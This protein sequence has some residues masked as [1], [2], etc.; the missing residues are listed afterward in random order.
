MEGKEH[1][2]ILLNKLQP[3]EIKTKT[4]RRTRLLNMIARNL[5]KKVTLLCA[6]AGYGKTTLLSHFF[7][8][9][10]L[11]FVYYHLEKTDAEPAVF[12]SYL[13][14]GIKR[15]IPAF[16]EKVEGLR[17]LFNS[18][19]HY[20]E[21][22]VG[23]FINEII[24][25]VHE[26]VYIILEDYHAL[27]PA[28]QVDKI[29]GYLFNHM[30]AKLHF[31][32]TSRSKPEISFSRMTA[33]D[34]FLE[35]DTRQL[36]FTKEEIRRLFKKVYAITLKTADLDWVEKYS[37]GWPVSLRLM[38]QSSQYLNGI[39]SDHTRM[40]I[41]DYVQSR[42]SLF[43]Y[44]AQEIF[45]QEPPR[46]RDFLLDCS[47]FEWLSPGLCDAVARRKNSGR[48]LSELTRRN[49]FVVR[50]PEHGYRFHHLFK[51]FLYSKLTDPRR[52]KS[53]YTRAG[54]YFRK[55]DKYDEALRYY[56][57]ANAHEKMVS[58]IA[59]V[60][61]SY[62]GQG[63]SATLCRFA[64]QIPKNIRRKNIDV[65]INYALALLNVGNYDEARRVSR[66]AYS[67]LKGRRGAQRRCVEVLY[68]LGGIDSNQGRFK[69]AERR[70]KAALKSCPEVSNLTRASVLNALG[71][72]YNTIGGNYINK[73]TDYF[74][75]A[76][77]IAQKSGYREIEGSILNNWA[78]SELKMGNLN[79]AHAKLSRIVPILQKHFSPGCGAGFCNAAK[80][81]VLLGHE[82]EA[83]STLDLGVKTCNPY[84]DLWSMAALWL[85]YGLLY[86]DAGELKKAEQHVNKS[87]QVYQKFGIERL[88]VAATNELAKI[89]IAN[90]DYA[91]AEK[92]I[93]S[94]WSL[95]KV[96]D[97]T[98]SIPVYLT[99]AK[100]KVAQGKLSEAEEILLKSA[101]LAQSFN[102]IFQR[103]LANVELSIVFY[104]KKE[105]EKSHNALREAVDIS[106]RK[107]YDRILLKELQGQRWML[108]TLREQDI[109]KRYVVSLVKESKLDLHW[110]DAFLFGVPR[111]FVDDQLI[112]DDVWKTIK[113]KK[114]FFYML[115]HKDEKLSSDSL[116]DTLWR[117]VSYKRGSDSLRKA[118]QHIREITKSGTTTRADL[119]VSIKGLYR[120][121]PSVSMCL[122][123]EAFDNL[124]ERVKRSRDDEERAALLGKIIALYKGGFAQGWYDRWVED[125]R[126]FYG[127][128]YE[129]CLLLT[130]DL[131]YRKA[132][133]RDSVALYE[134]LVARNPCEEEHYRRL[135]ES[136]GKLGKYREIRALF[137]KLKKNLKKELN[138]EPQRP[139]IELYR[140]LMQS[141]RTAG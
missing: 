36:R 100:L 43:N 48:V 1:G 135:M 57:Q 46:V 71:T 109:E 87:L 65:M 117:D 114:L 40:M 34:E 134:K 19:Q 6:G 15:L 26:D 96:R 25:N 32:I 68:S 123:T 5:D 86:Q 7:F 80:L 59:K 127:S 37:E 136:L 111:V 12:F 9:E 99:T 137:S 3:P 115:L 128:R 89:S 76:L 95:K 35:L 118:I 24:E 82:K 62:I 139:T 88:I 130:A 94:I 17:H 97:D 116:V 122:D 41:G 92:H 108:Q 93:A 70:Y 140:S 45:F 91:S 78:W 63:R 14:A 74:E 119:I 73:A 81:S 4:L 42:A 50:I 60:G 79:E 54:D 141:A 113:A 31:I 138:T 64:S 29:L 18:P 69:A 121:S 11:P 105:M 27:H 44:F 106:R 55:N 85:G 39:S 131:H 132:E 77:K 107:G 53:L 10:N 72:L 110:V 28:T 61:A 67:M 120:I 23:T 33:R 102:E 51:D 129:E 103:F 83:K 75:Q 38:L 16:G 124:F 52:R 125:M 21:I 98:D 2:I 104:Q 47:V 84:N 58:V 126:R 56:S 20:L 30:P 133:Y 22:I 8:G 49:A 101:E 90:H 66:S 13:V 112:A